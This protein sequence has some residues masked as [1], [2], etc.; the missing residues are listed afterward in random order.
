MS[1]LMT[2][3]RERVIHVTQTWHKCWMSR[4]LSSTRSELT[5]VF[6]RKYVYLTGQYLFWYL[7]LLRMITHDQL[8]SLANTLGALAMLTVVAYHFITVNAPHLS[9][10]VAN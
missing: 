1:V 9:K 4:G 3:W 8:Y 5:I 10:P 2:R 7:K 6:D